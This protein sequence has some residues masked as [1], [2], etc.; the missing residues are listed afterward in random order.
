MGYLLDTNIVSASLKQNIEV[1]LKIT[2][3]RRQGDF[4][5]ISGITYYEVQRGLLRSNATNKLAWFQEFCQDYPIL[6]LND[7]RI[8]EKASEIHTDLTKRGKIIQDAD[9]LIAA[10][11]IIHNLVLVSHDSDLTRVKDL[12]LE[13]WL[14]S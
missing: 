9:I 1:A 3:I 12:Q 4:I 5:G 13:N 10:T 14:I 7:L 6:F 11:A 2:E 8:F